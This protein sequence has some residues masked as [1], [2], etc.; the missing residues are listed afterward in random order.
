[1]HVATEDALEQRLGRVVHRSL[2]IGVL[3]SGAL[4]VLGLILA[5]GQH[6][7]EHEA[8]DN[9]R[10]LVEQAAAGEG[11]SLIN[12]GLI[13]LMLTPVVRVLV[14]A[15]GWS[16]GRKLWLAGVA[17]LVALLLAASMVLGVG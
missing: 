15:I 4:M 1:M 3:I 10:L 5:V 8:V 13:A 12:L 2:L 9:W 6:P 17:A 11:R 7:P 16:L 14:L